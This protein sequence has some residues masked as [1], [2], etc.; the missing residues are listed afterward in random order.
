MEKIFTERAHLMCP[1]MNFGITM[2]L[3]SIFDKERIALAFERTAGNHPFL[4]ALP[5]YSQAENSYFYDVI[6]TSQRS[7]AQA[8]KVRFSFRLHHRLC[9]KQ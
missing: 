5:G 8:S 9:G 3:D 4:K 1:R 7:K 6:G 2:S